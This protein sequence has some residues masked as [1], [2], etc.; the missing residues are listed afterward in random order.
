MILSIRSF[1]LAVS[2][3][4]ST[5]AY[6]TCVVPFGGPGV[7][8]TLG[9][10]AMLPNCSTDASIVFQEHTTYNISTPVVFS[11]LSHVEINI[12][13]NLDLPKSIPYVQAAVNASGGRLYWFSISGDNVTLSGN[14]D[15]E[16]G[17]IDPYGVPWWQA[18]PDTQPLGGLANRP[19]GFMIN[20]NNSIIRRLKVRKPVAW[21]ISVAG[22]NNH[23]YDNVIDASYDLNN[24]AVFPFNTDGYDIRGN[25]YVIENG[26]VSNGDDCV[27][28]NSG[29]NIT[30]RN[31][32]CE[33]GHGASLS[34]ANGV[35][36]VL[37][38][39]IT[40]KNSLYA[41]RFKSSLNSVGNITNVTW[42]NIYVLNATFPIFAT[43]VYFDQNTNR[44]RVPGDYPANSTATHI[45]NFLW[46]NI[47]GTISDIYTGDGSC[48]TNPCWYNV[49]NA[50]NTAA[51]TLQLLRGTATN[52]RVENVNLMPIDGKG[53]PN[54]LCDPSSFV[55]GTSNLGFKCEN[56]PYVPQ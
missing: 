23:I 31:M 56:G 4:T 13:G 26:T 38:N 21:G 37:F 55:D 7:D 18:A 9:L 28:V 52:I 8:D 27:A 40:S 50:T 30:V 15:P 1:A 49:A 53:T 16:W 25:N 34:S 39:N 42:S 19:H 35:S 2:L 33:G 11:N 20:A 46:T 14:Q 51:V 43:G 22:N 44:G 17:F 24:P 41:T 6:K 36:N 10:T 12:L 54:V 32:V 48:T 47:T 29:N 3:A 5:Q 45:S